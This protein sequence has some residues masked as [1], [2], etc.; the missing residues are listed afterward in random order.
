[1]D[2]RITG[3]LVGR[4]YWRYRYMIT[5]NLARRLWVAPSPVS[6]SRVSWSWIHLLGRAVGGDGWACMHVPV[7]PACTLLY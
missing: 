1:M 6:I 3:G 4:R 2:G 5:R 7:L